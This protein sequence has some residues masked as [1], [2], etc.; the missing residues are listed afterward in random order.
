MKAK[1]KG[2]VKGTNTE[3][4]LETVGK[5]DRAPTATTRRRA[6]GY[7]LR[8]SYGTELMYNAPIRRMKTM[9]IAFKQQAFLIA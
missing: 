6:E 1:T 7:K 4:N 3:R 8:F 2:K 9:Q 5:N